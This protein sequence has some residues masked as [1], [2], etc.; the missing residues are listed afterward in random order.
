M[1]KYTDDILTN[2]ND[3]QLL[4]PSWNLYVLHFSETVPLFGAPP[5]AT[6]FAFIMV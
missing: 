5:P 2:A 3:K 6:H 4:L 1:G